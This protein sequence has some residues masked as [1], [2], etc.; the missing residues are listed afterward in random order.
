[1]H[2]FIASDEFNKKK[3]TLEEHKGV[4]GFP[5]WLKS[6]PSYPW[7]KERGNYLRCIEGKGGGKI[8]HCSAQNAALFVDL[9]WYIWWVHL[10][11]HQKT[12]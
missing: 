9:F 7:S 10:N 6:Q 2:Y 12:Y 1:M 3:S 4:Q 11:Y 8:I 5:N